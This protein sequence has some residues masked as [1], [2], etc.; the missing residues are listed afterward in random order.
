MVQYYVQDRHFCP[1]GGTR[2]KWIWVH[3]PEAG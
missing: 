1:N 2:M 3:P